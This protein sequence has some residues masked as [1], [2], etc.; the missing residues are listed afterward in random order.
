MK[1]DLLKTMFLMAVGLLVGV[2][3]VWATEPNTDGYSIVY[4]NDFESGSSPWG[5]TGGTGAAISL[6]D[7]TGGNHFLSVTNNSK[8]N[9]ALPFA[10]N[11]SK[12]DLTFKWY[13]KTT[14]NE[15]SKVQLKFARDYSNLTGTADKYQFRFNDEASAT[16][17]TLQLSLGS[18]TP[19]QQMTNYT[20]ATSA[21]TSV[22]SQFYTVRVASDGVNVRFTFTNPESVSVTYDVAYSSDLQLGGIL[23][24]SNTANTDVL[25]I[26]DIVL[27]V[28]TENYTINYK[29]GDDIIKTETGTAADGA[30]ISATLPFTKD[31]QKYYAQT[32]ETTTSWTKSGE[33]M[34]TFNVPLRLANTYS[35]LVTA[36]GAGDD[37]ELCNVSGIVEGES[38]TVPYP[39]YYNVNGTLYEADK[40]DSKY[41]K[42]FSDISSNQNVDVSYSASSKTNIA[43]YTEGEDITGIYQTSASSYA[44]QS[45]NGKGGA[46]GK[47][48]VDATYKQF[49]TLPAGKYTVTMRVIG[50]TGKSYYVA[51]DSEGTNMV[52]SI[53]NT[54]SS[55]VESTSSEFT[56]DSETSLYVKGGYQTTSDQAYFIDYVYVQQTA[57]SKT[58]T[59]AGWATYCSPYALDLEHATG[60]T[61]A[62]IVTGGATGVLTKSSVQGGTV[63]ANTGLLIKGDAGTA[64]IP[65]VASGTDHSATN[66]LVGVTTETVLDLDSD[67]DGTSDSYVYVLMNDATNG[68]GFYKTTTTSFTVGANTAY[69]PANFD[70]S[71]ARFFSLFDDDATGI[72]DATRLN[73]NEKMTNDNCFDLQGRRVAQPKKGLYIVN[74]KKVI[75]K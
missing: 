19:K 60:L 42:I 25:Y 24:Q 56:L 58:I 33:D 73:D 39:R 66:K 63:A 7:E 52:L 20:Q 14:A 70:G 3:F 18:T 69:L 65:V 15:K 71:G 44:N 13:A 34:E 40:T 22:S 43:N 29:L 45:S 23:M 4:S 55:T 62:Y 68:L 5:W 47:Y 74:G 1:R 41:A 75:I 64:T 46:T 11:Y 50:K 27:K 48:S 36:K 21:P 16:S 67:D 57:V 30:T 17:P 28:P 54:A 61:D 6:I 8:Y 53:E 37:K 9:R 59:A 32:N 38:Y 12:Y 35:I 72:S 10:K 31:A 2:N 26:D 51:K 49:V